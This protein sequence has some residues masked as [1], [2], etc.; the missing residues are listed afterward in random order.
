MHLISH[1]LRDDGIALK[2]K[3]LMVYINLIQLINKYLRFITVT[4]HH[5]I[6]IL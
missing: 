2:S 4:F 3:L 6:I 5:R 1:D